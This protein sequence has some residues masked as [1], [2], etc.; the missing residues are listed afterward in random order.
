MYDDDLAGA[1]PVRVRVLFRRTPVRSPARVADA[2]SPVDRLEPDHFFEIA[3]LSLGTTNLQPVAI[4]GDSDACRVITAI[5]Q[6]T[7]SVYNDRNNALFAD[8]P[9]DPAHISS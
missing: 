9:D 1:I 5:F 7:Q 8:I 2:I 6:P 3:Q 4:P